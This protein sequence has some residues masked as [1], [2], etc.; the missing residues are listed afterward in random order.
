MNYNTICINDGQ[1]QYL[2]RTLERVA[3]NAPLSVALTLKRELMSLTQVFFALLIAVFAALILVPIVIWI[4]KK[5]DQALDKHSK[6]IPAE[7]Y[8]V[9]KKANT[10]IA[11]ENFST[12]SWY[13]L[14]FIL[15]TF[16]LVHF[17]GKIEYGEN[18][19]YITFLIL[20]G[21]PFLIAFVHVVAKVDDQ[22]NRLL[23]SGFSE[24]QATTHRMKWLLVVPGLMVL[25]IDIT[26]Q[27]ANSMK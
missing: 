23:T 4:I 22:S 10:I 16:S 19:P 21:I 7:P 26:L 27:V 15:V 24:G 17:L 1:K 20:V 9:P 2:T 11:K 25:V 5:F 6:N 18:L 3:E 13:L 14:Y 12:L 8:T